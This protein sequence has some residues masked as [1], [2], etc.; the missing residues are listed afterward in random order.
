[1]P[2]RAG[3]RF[4]IEA[5]FIVLV[6][7]GAAF[8]ELSTPAIVLVIG[9]AWLLVALSEWLASRQRPSPLAPPPEPLEAEPEIPVPA[10]A[11]PRFDAPAAP[12]EADTAIGFQSA[13]PGSA[14]P[15]AAE[16]AAAEPDP[17]ERGAEVPFSEP[18][19]TPPRRRFWQRGTGREQQAPSAEAAP[20]RHV[21]R[22]SPGSD[23]A[24][25]PEGER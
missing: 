9:G 22:L 5:V 16:V 4:A 17:W 2:A 11:P 6:A 21:R 10:A 23:P 18:V 1:M 12:A 14:E 24:T 15:D 20:P 13:Q 19:E 25:S 3:R 7:V 8:A